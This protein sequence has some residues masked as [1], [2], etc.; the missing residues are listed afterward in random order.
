[1][2]FLFLPYD[3]NSVEVFIRSDYFDSQMEKLEQL[4]VEVSRRLENSEKL[5]DLL[6]KT[7]D[8]EFIIELENLFNLKNTSL[9]QVTD[10]PI[11]KNK[12]SL[13]RWRGL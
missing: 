12:R 7:Q 13:F 8:K 10:I 11:E 3:S 2:D 9:V 4:R 5:A 1:M 6:E